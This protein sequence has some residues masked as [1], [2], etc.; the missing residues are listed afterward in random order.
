MKKFALALFVLLGACSQNGKDR[1]SHVIDTSQEISYLYVVSGKSGTYE[2]ELLT[3]K[4]AALVIYFSDRPHLVAGH[5][6]LSNFIDRW[7]SVA[8]GPLKDDT[9]NAVF[10]ILDEEQSV[11]VTVELSKPK[12]DKGSLSFRVKSAND[13]IPATFGPNSL[14]IEMKGMSPKAKSS[15][16]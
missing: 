3:L 8:K 9:P 6:P 4:P 13:K 15:Q 12:F 2:N 16:T 11:E 10:S 7:D 14:F 5:L 1:K